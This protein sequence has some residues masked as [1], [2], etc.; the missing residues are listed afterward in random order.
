MFST[1]NLNF[2]FMKKVREK[3]TYSI[4]GREWGHPFFEIVTLVQFTYVVIYLLAYLVR[5]KLVGDSGLCCVDDFASF[6]TL[7]I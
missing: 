6:D 3:N 7:N 1:Y 2:Y 5:V 4:W